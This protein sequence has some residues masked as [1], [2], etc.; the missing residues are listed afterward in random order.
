MT[1]TADPATGSPDATEVDTAAEAPRRPAL[2]PSRA[3]DF[4]QCPLLFRFRTVDRLPEPP[5]SAAARGTLVHAVL[6]RL[7]DAP[8]GERTP[9][10]ARALLPG[11]WERLVEVEPRYAELFTPGG[12]ATGQPLETWLE[13]AGRLLGTYFTLEDPNRL[14]PA[15]RELKVE[16]QLEDGPLL[17]GVVDRLDVAPDGAVRVVDYKSGRSPRPGFEA[18][19][20]FQMRFYG[21]VVWRERGVLPKMLQ[22]VYLGDGQVLRAEPR[23]RE[24]EVTEAKVRS[25]WDAITT[26]ARRGE[27]VPKQSKLCGWCAHQAVCPAFDGT[28]PPIPTDAL[29]RRL[30]VEV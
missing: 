13:G 6:E 8:L 19:A 15:A 9:E 2:S 22:L 30:G 12:D 25:L 16:S 23:A 27:F 26:A 1:T 11:E 21:L 10:A 14:E 18:S 17:R 7:Y 3:N 4:M 20:L 24:L 28:P 29:R 5:S